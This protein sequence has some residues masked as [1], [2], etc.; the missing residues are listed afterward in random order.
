MFDII[1]PIFLKE[2]Y[3]KRANFELK[4]GCWES[5]DNIEFY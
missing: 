5:R 4:S 2:P 3:E 1:I